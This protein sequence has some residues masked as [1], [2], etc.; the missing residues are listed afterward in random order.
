MKS[1]HKNLNP[2]PM[3]P[4]DRLVLHKCCD[5]AHHECANWQ[6]GKCVERDKSCKSH[7]INPIFASIKDGA[8]NCDWFQQAVLPLDPTLEKEVRQ[9]FSEKETAG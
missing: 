2:V 9:A 5:L 6:R 3:A 4:H 8:L 1:T 7:L